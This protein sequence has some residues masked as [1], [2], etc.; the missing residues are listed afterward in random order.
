MLAAGVVRLGFAR[1]VW[2]VFAFKF[3]S[4]PSMVRP[5]FTRRTKGFV[6]FSDRLTTLLA[7]LNVYCLLSRPP[8]A[9]RLFACID[10]E[11]TNRR[12]LDA[13]E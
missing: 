4:S 13:T 3:L 1:N 10:T 2:K 12:F 5:L 8:A 6:C 11:K 7:A 9:R